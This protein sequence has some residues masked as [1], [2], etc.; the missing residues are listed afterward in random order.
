MERFCVVTEKFYVATWLARLD[1]FSVT[2]KYFWVVK[3]LAKAWRNY[4]A[5]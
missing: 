4:V 1:R 5:T 3:V 2:T